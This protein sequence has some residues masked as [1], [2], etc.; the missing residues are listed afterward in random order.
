[1]D[2][3]YKGRVKVILN[4]FGETKFCTKKGK[5]IAK[6][7]TESLKQLKQI[8]LENIVVNCSIDHV[9]QWFDIVF[10]IIRR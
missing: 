2:P 10:F 1:M 6:L 7:I 3:G 5:R 4:H 8:V 9:E